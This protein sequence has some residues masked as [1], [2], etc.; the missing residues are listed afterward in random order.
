METLNRKLDIL[1]PKKRN[2]RQIQP[3]RDPVDINLFP[4][5]LSNAG[6]SF[7]KIQDLKGAQIRTAYKILY[8]TGLRINESI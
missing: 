4:I 2:E 6:E 1:L 3:L 7:S 8:H 5:F